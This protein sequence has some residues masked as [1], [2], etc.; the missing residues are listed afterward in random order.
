MR[1]DKS[2][3]GCQLTLQLEEVAVPTDEADH[4]QFLDDLET[5][6]EAVLTEHGLDAD[7]L[8][9]IGGHSYS[10]IDDRCPVCSSELKLIEPALDPYNGAHARASCECGWSGEAVYRLID[11]H[12]PT[13]GS[14]ERSVVDNAE[15]GT[16]VF[17][18]NSSVSLYDLEPKYYP[19]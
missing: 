3:T 4:E 18:E 13:S 19:Y 7:H 17:D 6:L 1:Y 5:A 14:D 12:E 8:R 10:A 11:L 15:S 16:E 2:A 9:A